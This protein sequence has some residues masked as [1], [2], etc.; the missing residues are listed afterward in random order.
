MKKNFFDS[1]HFFFRH[2]SF[3][4]PMPK[5]GPTQIFWTTP[6]TPK[7]RPTLPTPF[8]WPTP[9][10]NGPMPPTPFFWP[11]PKF[12]R[13]TSPTPPTSKF[14]QRHPWTHA[15]MRPTLPTLPILSMQPR[16]SCHPHPLADSKSVKG[17]TK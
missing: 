9:K 10:F 6:P 15:S 2:K 8:L 1:L 13:P 11:T 3:S 16:Y 7:F 4:W 14:D 5:F 12:H 17:A